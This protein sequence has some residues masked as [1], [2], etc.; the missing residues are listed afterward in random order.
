MNGTSGLY[1]AGR[2]ANAASMEEYKQ[3]L[4]AT[5]AKIAALEDEGRRNSYR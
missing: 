1:S 4:A 5:Q 2:V 3:K